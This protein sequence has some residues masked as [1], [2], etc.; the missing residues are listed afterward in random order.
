MEKLNEKNLLV[1]ALA[2]WK[3]DPSF[4]L[5][6]HA[7]GLHVQQYLQVCHAQLTVLNFLQHLYE[8]F[9]SP[10]Q[11]TY[12][13]FSQSLKEGLSK[14]RIFLLTFFPI[15]LYTLWQNFNP[16]LSWFSS[17]EDH[18]KTKRAKWKFITYTFTWKISWPIIKTDKYEYRQK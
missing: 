1:Q 6:Y 14:S 3:K 7:I 18:K 9:K 2:I 8:P 16:I 10:C 13:P 5:I 11:L 12:S 17:F 4:L 15:N